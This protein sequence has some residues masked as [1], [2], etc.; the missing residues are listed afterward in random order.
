MSSE[1]LAV[2]DLRA[3]W[4]GTP[5]LRGISFDVR[6]GEFVVLLG[7]NGSGKTTLLRCLAGLEAIDGG[8]IELNGVPI[9]RWP[10]HRRGIGLVSQEPSLFPHRTVVDNIAYGALLQRLP[11]AEVV[12]RVEGLLETLDLGRF[13]DRYPTQLSGG[14]AQ[15]VALARA[16]APEPALVL[17]DEPFASVDPELRGELRA[18]FRHLLAERNV[19]AIHV[20]HDRDEGSFLGERVLILID[21]SVVQEGAPREVYARPRTAAIARFLGFNILPGPTGPVAVLPEGVSVQAA[22]GSGVP[23]T[24]IASG[25]VGRSLSI[26]LRLAD[27][28]RV[29]ARRPLGDGNVPV[30]AR[31]VLAWSE[32]IPFAAPDD[33][34]RSATVPR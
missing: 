32:G 34:P 28:T 29:E 9:E 11:P 3:S 1:L 19:A 16:L 8:G 21:G 7:P 23:A 15:R 5:V 13:R 31:V 25:P 18:E 12:R 30:G 27:G 2:R 4:D 33:A 17:L 24:V 20:T 6:V 10:T 26:H 22:G 14:E